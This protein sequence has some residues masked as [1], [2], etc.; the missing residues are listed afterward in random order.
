MISHKHKCIFIHIPKCAG[1]SIESKLGH[2]E[3]HNGYGGQDHRSLRMI[4]QP[5]LIPNTFLSMENIIEL[6]RREKHQHIN[7]VSNPRN[8]YTVT[9]QQYKS[10]FKFSIVRNPWSRAYSLYKNVITD[11][12][13]LKNHGITKETSFKEFLQ[14]FAGK[15]LLKSQMYWIKNFKGQIPLDY[16]GRFENL[17]Q[18]TQEIFKRLE[19]DETS[20]PHMIKGSGDDYRRHYD[21]ET[22]EIISDIYKEEIEMFGYKF[23]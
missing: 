17:H 22:N 8:K 1:T 18:D 19:M 5:Y 12:T 11:E 10:Y 15:R 9:E 7:K 16:I 3:N 2:L 14:N 23:D 20:L 21:K 6:L 4:E 13:H